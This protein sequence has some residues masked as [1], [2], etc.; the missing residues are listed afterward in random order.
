[1][2]QHPDRQLTDIQLDRKFIEY[3]SAVNLNREALQEMLR[4]AREDDIVFVHSMDRLARTVKD[5][6]E[7]VTLL[8]KKNVIVKFVKEGLEFGR[9]NSAMSML[10]LHL[11]GAFAEFEHAFIRERQMEGIKIA[12][13]NGKYRG[14]HPKLNAAHIEKL[15]KELLTRKSKNQI[16]KDMGV[17]RQ[18]LYKYI[19][20]LGVQI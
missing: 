8:T 13:T 15:R 9:D 19:D 20:R 12:K 3:A 7:V 11:M 14:G 16:A 6:K 18:T 10:T 2:D 4:F 17:S 5:L 1:V